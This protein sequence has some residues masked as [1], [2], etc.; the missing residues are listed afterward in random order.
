LKRNEVVRIR[1]SALSIQHS[2]R[3]AAWRWTG[4]FARQVRVSFP[5]ENRRLV[6]GIYRNA[7]AFVF[8][9]SMACAGCAQS[10]MI[11]VTVTNTS[12]EKIST[13][14]IDY[15]EATFGINSL[16]PGKSFHDK[17]KPTATGNLKIEFLDAHGAGH[18]SQ[19][20]VLRKRDEG[21]IEIQLTQDG[22][23]IVEKAK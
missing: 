2:A 1:H 3:G 22:A 15:P 5:A 23:K 4:I 12:P 9:L 20:P 11:Q 8:S 14:V 19:G 17:I 18:V 16:E 7:L 21:S 13:I 6:Y 10:H